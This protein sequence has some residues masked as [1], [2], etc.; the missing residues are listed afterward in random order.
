L[1]GIGLST[2][3]ESVL[4]NRIAPIFQKTWRFGISP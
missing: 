4:Q 1:P 3:I 2:A